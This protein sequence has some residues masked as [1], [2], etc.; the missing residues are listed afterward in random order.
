MGNKTQRKRRRGEAAIKAGIDPF[1]YL[2]EQFERSYKALKRGGGSAETRL[3]H[4][5]RA[6]QLAAEL[7]PF[8]KPKL[9]AVSVTQ[10]VEI[11]AHV[12][13]GGESGESTG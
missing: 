4:Q 8:I 6:D 12:T 2:L 11:E 1:D 13:I 5:E 7:L 3:K 10:A 9:R